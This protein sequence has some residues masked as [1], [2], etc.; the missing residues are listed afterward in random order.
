MPVLKC[1]TSFEAKYIMRDIH[2]G[3]YGNHARGQSLAFKALGQGYY[4]PTLKANCIEY[5]RKC[6][7]CL[8][9]SPMSKAHPE[10]LTSM[11]SPWP[12]AL[13][14]I[15]LIDRLP[16]GKGSVQ[17]AVVAIDYFIKWVAAEALVSN[18]PIKINELVYKN[19]V[20]WYGVPHTIV[21][22]NGT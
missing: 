1:A 15:D 9:F 19:I 20:Y 6:D 7:K 22:D 21:S 4:W 17:Y 12:F 16:K 10:K 18:T 5:A 2:K 11:T 8:Q 14:G 3:T 13:W